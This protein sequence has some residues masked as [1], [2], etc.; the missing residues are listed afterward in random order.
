MYDPEFHRIYIDKARLELAARDDQADHYSE[1]EA[2]SDSQINRSA[3]SIFFSAARRLLG[4]QSSQPSQPRET[5]EVTEAQIDR[6]ATPEYVAT[7]L[8]SLRMH[9]YHEEQSLAREQQPDSSL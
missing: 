8:A 9:M 7:G 2:E 1:P 5:I 6:N 4:R 3:L